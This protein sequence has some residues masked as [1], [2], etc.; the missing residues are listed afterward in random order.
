M[1]DSD[2]TSV[3]PAAPETKVDESEVILRQIA[4]LP[5][6]QKTAF[7]L[8]E[9]EGMSSTEA[10]FIMGCKDSTARVHLARAKDTLRQKLTEMGI[11]N[12]S[13]L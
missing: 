3:T 7:I 5:V 4:R 8:I 10:A 6:K 9:I 11:G 1:S 2:S 13:I 12:D